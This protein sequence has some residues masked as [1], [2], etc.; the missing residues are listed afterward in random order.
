MKIL[1]R[2][3]LIIPV[4]ISISQQAFAQINISGKIQNSSESPVSAAVVTLYQAKGAGK[5]VT[6]GATDENGEFHIASDKGSYLLKV[7]FLQELLYQ[8]EITVEK[9]LDLGL[10]TVE[11]D[12]KSK[13]LAEVEIRKYK[14][15][16][17][18][19]NGKLEFSTSVVE[20]GSVLEIMKIAPTVQ[21]QEDQINLLGKT[22]TEIRINGRKIHMSGEQLTSYLATLSANMLEKLEIVHNP[23][24]EYDADAKGGVINIVLKELKEKGINASTY[25]TQTKSKYAN[26]SLGGNFNMLAGK[27]QTWGSVGV[28]KGK[29]LDLRHQ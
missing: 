20:T 19:R 12:G 23:G 6:A 14:P 1:C 18:F 7:T 22:G 13:E 15:T 26:T 4:F 2:L 28:D 25:V 11:K 27:W 16:V 9:Q 3:L 10:I 8:K 29:K 5:M 21:I 17:V 24:A